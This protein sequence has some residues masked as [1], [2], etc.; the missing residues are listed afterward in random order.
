MDPSSSDSA[1]DGWRLLRRPHGRLDFVAADGTVHPDVDVLRAFPVTAPL[2]PVAVVAADGAELAW[3]DTLATLPEAFRARLLGELS[4]REF[5]PVIERIE[6][7]ADSDPAEWTVAT[8]RGQRRFAV[9]SP[10]DV[11]RL[12]DGSAF[13]VDTAGVRYRIPDTRALDA[14]SRRLLDRTME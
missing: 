3:I 6:A 1:P 5:L 2:G 10:E 4:A 14:H 11:E 9:A 13:V 7:I 12:P 8:D